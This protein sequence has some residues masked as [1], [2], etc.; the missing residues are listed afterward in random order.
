MQKGE[1]KKR[2]GKVHTQQMK[3]QTNL[4]QEESLIFDTIDGLQK[5]DP[6]LAIKLTLP[7]WFQLQV[8]SI[9]GS[10]VVAY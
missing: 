2:P 1:N 6:L 3:P 8:F 9:G 4:C 10:S 7:P 5:F